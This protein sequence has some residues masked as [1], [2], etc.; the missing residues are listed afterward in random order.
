M[1][2]AFYEI[3]SLEHGWNNDVGKHEEVDGTLLVGEKCILRFYTEMSSM[4]SF[5]A[6]MYPAFYNGERSF[7]ITETWKADNGYSAVCTQD[8]IITFEDGVKILIKN[9]VFNFE[10]IEES[11]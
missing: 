1:K 3:K 5:Y 11:K 6:K 2:M 7:F 8:K 9:G 10:N 4:G